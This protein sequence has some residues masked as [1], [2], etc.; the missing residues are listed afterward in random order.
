MDFVLYCQWFRIEI[1]LN[2]EDYMVLNSCKSIDIGFL[3]IDFDI[4]I[5][6]ETEQGLQE[7]ID[8]LSKYCEKWKLV[9]NVNRTKVMVFRKRGR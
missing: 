6:S 7:G 9:V 8:V 2:L 1:E 3:Y 4:V 5:F